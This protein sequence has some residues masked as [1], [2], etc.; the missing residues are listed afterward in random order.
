MTNK[1]VFNVDSQVQLSEI[2]LRHQHTNPVMPAFSINMFSH[3]VV[4]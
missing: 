1:R 4:G 3:T 2:S